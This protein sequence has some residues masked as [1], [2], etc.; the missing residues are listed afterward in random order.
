MRPCR[1]TGWPGLRGGR[2]PY[3]VAH[4]AL[5]GRGAARSA[6]WWKEAG[7][8]SALPPLRFRHIATKGPLPLSQKYRRRQGPVH[9]FYR[10]PRRAVRPGSRWGSRDLSAI[11]RASVGIGKGAGRSARTGGRP[12]TYSAPGPGPPA[13]GAWAEGRRK[14]GE[15]GRPFTGE[16]AGRGENRG[17]GRNQYG[18]PRVQGKRPEP[19]SSAVSFSRAPRRTRAA[20][21]T[22]RP[23]TP[24]PGAEPGPGW[25]SRAGPR[26]RPGPGR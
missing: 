14:T 19:Q 2:G 16:G 10:E 1:W 3:H 24:G 25:A 18:V 7:S 5:S 12:L 15:A 6:I 8:I 17:L 20:A 13:P 4:S 21:R 9:D 23:G 22:S 11:S 26:P